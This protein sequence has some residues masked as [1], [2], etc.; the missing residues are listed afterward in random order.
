[1]ALSVGLLMVDSSGECCATVSHPFGAWKLI[2]Q[3]GLIDATY[4][5]R[6]DGMR[7]SDFDRTCVILLSAPRFC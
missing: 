3:M 6:M 7:L 5:H 2:D 4:L 1:L